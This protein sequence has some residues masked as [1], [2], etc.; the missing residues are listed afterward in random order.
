ME[1]VYNTLWQ[2]YSGQYVQHFIRII[3]VL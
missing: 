1:N 3:L 2:V